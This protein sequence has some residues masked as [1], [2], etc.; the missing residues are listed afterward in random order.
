M[1]KR[2][3]IAPIALSLCCTLIACS[4]DDPAA[5]ADTTAP[6]FGEMQ[7]H[8]AHEADDVDRGVALAWT[9][10]ADAGSG[11]VEYRVLLGT[12]DPPVDE[13]F[14]GSDTTCPAGPLTYETTYYWSV[15]AEDA[16]G[17]ETPSEIF[18]FTTAPVDDFVLVTAGTFVMGS[19]ENELPREWDE[20]QHTVTLTIDYYV[21]PFEVTEELWIA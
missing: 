5:P 14:A 15:V 2:W 8:P 6:D 20:T 11:T 1:K 7:V 17:N 18:H 10:A 12:V 4:D 16:A 3:L 13:V 21:S 9:A 19:P